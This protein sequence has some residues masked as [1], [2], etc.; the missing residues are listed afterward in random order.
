[1]KWVLAA[2]AAAQLPELA[3]EAAPPDPP[4]VR[5]YGKDPNILKPYAA[6]ELWPLTLSDAQRRTTRTL[7]DLIIP[8]DEFS[9]AA[10]AVATDQ[11]IDEWI[12]APYP[13][14]AVD[15]K[16]M[17]DGLAWIDE[18]AQRRFGALFAKLS[19]TQMT[20]IADELTAQPVKSELTDGAAF[21]VRYRALTAGG[22]YTT[23]VGM[24]DL[25]YVGNVPLTTFDGP[26]QEVLKKLGLV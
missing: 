12:S 26:P 1:M 23:P 24:R 11:F 2:G 3:F 18:E 20:T 14:H 7:C 8:A 5:G 15:R 13:E 17:L 9:P 19:P 22:F 4:N 16:T 10:T 6:G 21:F 25:K